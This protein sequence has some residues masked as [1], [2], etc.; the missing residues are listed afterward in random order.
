MKLLH[1]LFGDF[2]RKLVALIFA[3]V[4]YWQAGGFVRKSETPAAPPKPA[5]VE[6]NVQIS[7]KEEATREV[8]FPVGIINDRKNIK[9]VFASGGEQQVKV[10]LCGDD[11]TG[12]QSG[13][14]LRFYVD[15]AE[16]VPGK[17]TL[18]VR[19]HIRRAGVRVLS[20]VPEEIPMQVI[21]LE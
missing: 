11:L 15:T 6:E 3:V 17:N 1:F 7:I 10:T 4:I 14:D 13:G 18:R 20:V 2:W 21:P 5:K 8:E 9:A 16:L 12:I 19:C